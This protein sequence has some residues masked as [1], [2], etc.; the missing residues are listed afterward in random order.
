MARRTPP[1]QLIGSGLIPSTFDVEYGATEEDYAQQL[2]ALMQQER[3]LFKDYGFKG[4]IGTS[5]DVNFEIDPT[6]PFGQYQKY[7]RQAGTQLRG[8][9]QQNRGRGLG[10]T[11]LARA[12]QNLIRYLME[13]SKSELLGGFQKSA[14]DIFGRRGQAATARNRAMSGIQGRA[15]EWWNQYGPQDP[16]PTAPVP[17]NNEDPRVG[18]RKPGSILPGMYSTGGSAYP[19]LGGMGLAVSQ[20]TAEAAQVPMQLP[21]VEQVL[22]GQAPDPYT[23]GY[24][25]PSRPEENPIPGRKVRFY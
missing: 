20:P 11:G 8:A 21:S 6:A 2:A 12:R 24:V 1:A 15:L 9:R 7:L 19:K 10:R 18:A 3:G 17:A 5:G 4:G 25:V 23:S 14:G 16:D 13:S 22:S